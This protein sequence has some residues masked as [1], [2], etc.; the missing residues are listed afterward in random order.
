VRIAG[1]SLRQIL[2]N[3]ALNAIEAAPEGGHVRIAAAQ[4]GGSVEIAI[5]DDGP[6][7]PDA[8]RARV[9]EPFFSTKSKPGGLGLAITKRLVEDVG[10]SIEVEGCAPTGSRFCVRLPIAR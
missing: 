6:G 4:R 9:F 10:G 8:L 5:E 3:L 2:L 1:D 7:V